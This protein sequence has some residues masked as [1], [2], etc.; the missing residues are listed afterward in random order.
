MEV[1]DDALGLIKRGVTTFFA[2]KLAPTEIVC[3]EKE[4]GKKTKFQKQKT[5]VF[6]PGSLLSIRSK[7]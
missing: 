4:K 5:P 2:S 7:R 3:R 1:N 6:R